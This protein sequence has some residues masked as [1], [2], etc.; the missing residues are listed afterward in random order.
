MCLEQRNLIRPDPIKLWIFYEVD[1]SRHVTHCHTI[2]YGETG[3]EGRGAFLKL[4]GSILGEE[5]L[6]KPVRA[7]STIFLD[8]G[9][10]RICYLSNCHLVTVGE[11][12]VRIFLIDIAVAAIRTNSFHFSE[13]TP[14]EKYKFNRVFSLGRQNSQKPSFLPPTS[15]SNLEL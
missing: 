6:N 9:I 13:G 1:A 4:D 11:N 5:H 10:I 8:T 12:L 7:E 2:L 14:R 3:Y 15:L